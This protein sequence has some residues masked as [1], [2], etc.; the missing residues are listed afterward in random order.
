MYNIIN[1]NWK[2][3]DFCMYAVLKSPICTCTRNVRAPRDL[4]GLE[5]S[6]ALLDC[7]SYPLE[8]EYRVQNTQE[9]CIA[10]IGT[11]GVFYLS[12]SELKFLY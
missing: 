7:V 12:V 8:A 5:I 1:K 3:T 2:I 11:L 9:I 6:E 10:C 4:V